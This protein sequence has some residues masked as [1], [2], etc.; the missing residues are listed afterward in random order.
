M[1]ESCVVLFCV[2]CSVFVKIVHGGSDCWVTRIRTPQNR[3]TTKKQLV[4]FLDYAYLRDGIAR[5]EE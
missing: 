1:K 4:S 2:C 5:V 3:K